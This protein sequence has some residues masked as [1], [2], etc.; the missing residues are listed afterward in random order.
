M[1]RL[2]RSDVRKRLPAGTRCGRERRPNAARR[3]PTRYGSRGP[4]ALAAPL[5]ARFAQE[6]AEGFVRL[7]GRQA[8]Q[9]ELGLNNPTSAPQ[10]GED[11]GA[12]SGSEKRLLAFDLLTDVPCV[13]RGL[14]PV[15]RG[16]QCVAFI[17][18]CLL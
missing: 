17:P 13:R 2:K 4:L 14:M 6:A 1:A 16:L 18:Q 9:I 11:I 15:F 8:M 7:M 10:S 12:E 5:P 3:P